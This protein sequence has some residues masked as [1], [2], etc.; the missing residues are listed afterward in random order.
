MSPLAQLA[1]ALPLPALKEY[2][3]GWNFDSRIAVAGLVEPIMRT[4]TTAAWIERLVPL[5]VWVASVNTLDEAL[6]D[7]IVAGS[8]AIE[9][10][11]HPAAGRVKLL[12]LPVEF[13]TGRAGVRRLPP[14][15]GE[16]TEEILRELG[17]GA[18][19]IARLRDAGAV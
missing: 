12:R 15:S 10:I 17:Y 1:E 8:G 14:E 3:N 13:S 16:H 7:P 4:R 5:G 18:D 6:G 19:D 2:T 11:E 9:E